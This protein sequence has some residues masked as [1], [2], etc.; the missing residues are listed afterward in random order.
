MS[1]AEGIEGTAPLA[2][3]KSRNSSCCISWCAFRTSQL[4]FTPEWAKG[5][6]EV[7]NWA[8][9]AFLIFV[10]GVTGG[11]RRRRRWWW[12]RDRKTWCRGFGK[13]WRLA[14]HHSIISIKDL[15]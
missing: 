6:I 7:D 10:D 11:R 8:R 1:H 14:N 13:W 2:A 15:V 5:C 4:L 9:H 3:M 12:L